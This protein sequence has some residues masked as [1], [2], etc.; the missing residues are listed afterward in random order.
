VIKIPASGR[1]RREGHFEECNYNVKSKE[2]FVE[3]TNHGTHEPDRRFEDGV[4]THVQVSTDDH[5]FTPP[6]CFMTVPQ[7]TQHPS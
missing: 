1:R 7:N 5:S 4:A 6:Q 3:V 2:L